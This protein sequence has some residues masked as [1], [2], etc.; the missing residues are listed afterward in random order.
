MGEATCS[1]WPVWKVQ[2]P[3]M[4]VGIALQ[5]SNSAFSGVFHGATA[6]VPCS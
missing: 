2:E 6:Q 1:D 3:A 5:P 4:L